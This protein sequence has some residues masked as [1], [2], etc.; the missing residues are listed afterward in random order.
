MATWSRWPTLSRTTDTQTRTAW[1]RWDWFFNSRK[2]RFWV[3]M[4]GR[5][6]ARVFYAGLGAF[7]IAMGTLILV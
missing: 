1:N 4:I 5:G 7:I 3:N 6:G 2:A